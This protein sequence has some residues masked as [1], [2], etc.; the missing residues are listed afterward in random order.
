[1]I[2]SW[3][4]PTKRRWFRAQYPHHRFIVEELGNANST[5]AFNRFEEGGHV[6]RFHG[7]FRLVDLERDAL[8]ALGTPTIYNL[9]R[10]SI[11]S[12]TFC[13]HAKEY[14]MV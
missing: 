3:F 13:S 4:N 12:K 5:H 14:K 1:M 11:L 6:K 10:K 8:Y 9:W 2:Q 7:H